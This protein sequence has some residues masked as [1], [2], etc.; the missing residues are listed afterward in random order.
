MLD[1]YFE[2]FY[3]IAW[4]DVVDVWGQPVP[5]PTDGEAVQGLFVPDQSAEVMVAAT[6]AMRTKGRFMAAADA[7]ITDLDTLRNAKHGYFLSLKSDPLVAPG[8]SPTQSKRFL[9]EITSRPSF[10]GD[11]Q[12]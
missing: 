1:Q 12:T 10:E 2:T 3:K 5:T 9:A 4:F 11:G 7:P 6:P 8:F